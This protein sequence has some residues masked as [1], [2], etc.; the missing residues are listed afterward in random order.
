MITE[1]VC[2]LSGE[3][4]CGSCDPACESV[5]EVVA[6]SGY[7]RRHECHVLGVDEVRSLIHAVACAQ[8]GNAGSDSASAASTS[9]QRSSAGPDRAL[10]A[11]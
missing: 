1:P 5:E 10:S 8:S 11:P 7:E 6:V 9:A 4:L 3:Y 2:R